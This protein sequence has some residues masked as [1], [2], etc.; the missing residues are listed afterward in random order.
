M[1]DEWGR[2][3]NTY[4]LIF[5]RELLLA[6]R[7]WDKIFRQAFEH[8]KPGGWLELGCTVPQPTSDDGTME[9]GP[10]YLEIGVHFLEMSRRMGTSIL[11]PYSWKS[12]MQAIGFTNVTE[13]P[14]KVPLGPWPKDKTLKEVGK[15]ESVH[16]PEALEAFALR[17][18]TSI[19]GVDYDDLQILIA[20]VREELRDPKM[21]SYVRFVAVY[22]QKP[23]STSFDN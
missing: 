7:D 5:C 17:G 14:F 22:G 18:F 19:L 8:L 11:E 21:H 3:A 15:I 6:I 20:R 13:I 23:E 2:G 12:K 4:D 9:Y 16:V 1:E 10:A